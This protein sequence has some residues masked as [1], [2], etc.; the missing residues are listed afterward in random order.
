[1]EISKRLR[2]IADMVTPNSVVCDVGTDHGYLA[3]YLIEQG[4][5]EKV[6][7]MD[8]AEG[9]LS[10]AQ[11]N[12]AQYHF[13]DQIETR[14]SDGLDELHPFE[15]STVV[16]A[17]MGGILITGLLEKGKAVLDT[18]R[19]LIVSPHTD[20][21]LTRRYLL[22]NGFAIAKERMLVEDGKYYIIMKAY[23]G[24]QSYDT[25]SEYRYGSGLLKERNP[26]LKE[27]LEKELVKNES[28]YGNLKTISTENSEKRRMELE[29]EIQCIK[30]GLMY[31]EM[32]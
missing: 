5:C 25:L 8:V 12:I 19:E 22:R 20:I 31:Y 28:L 4:I 6:I 10:K 14:L 27:Y 13:E 24:K 16:M 26:V 15:A 30:E 18:V 11:T 2:T 1:M 32:Q 3:I 23:H 7:A 29:E 9:P 17:G 21:E